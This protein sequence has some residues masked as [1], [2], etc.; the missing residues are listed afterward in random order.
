MLRCFWLLRRSSGLPASQC[1]DVRWSQASEP[2]DSHGWPG[3]RSRFSPNSI[4][5]QFGLKAGNEQPLFDTSDVF[6]QL[7]H[8][9]SKANVYFL[10][11]C[12]LVCIPNGPMMWSEALTDVTWRRL[13]V[14]PGDVTGLAPWYP[15][16]GFCFGLPL[17]NSSGHFWGRFVW[18]SNTGCKYNDARI[19]MRTEDERRMMMQR[20]WGRELLS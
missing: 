13:F 20:I 3:C 16:S 6:V 5:P 18:N 7:N 14:D 4:E 10:V 2:P 1:K 17:R 15:S 12:V 11:V 8:L 9:K 19:F